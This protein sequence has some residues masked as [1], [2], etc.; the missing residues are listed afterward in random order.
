MTSSFFHADLYS[1]NLHEECLQS[2]PDGHPHSQPSFN[3]P[4]GQSLALAPCHATPNF[5]DPPPH[6]VH[7]QTSR[8]FKTHWQ[9]PRSSKSSCTHSIH[10]LPPLNT[11]T[12]G[13]SLRVVSRM[14]HLAVIFSSSATGLIQH[15]HV[16]PYKAFSKYI[17]SWNSNMH[18]N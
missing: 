13:P 17:H 6:S 10:L 15:H 11:L 2:S 7:L 3:L 5:S 12:S 16:V 9:P 4:L 1:H 14:L 8:T 18:Q